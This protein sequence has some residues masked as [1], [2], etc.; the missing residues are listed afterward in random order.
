[1]AYTK[2]TFIELAFEELGI[3]DYIFDLQPEE[4][5]KAVVRLDGMMARWAV[6]GVEVG[7]PLAGSPEDSDIDSDVDL[8]LFAIEP[9]YTNLAILLGP[10][11][12]KIASPATKKTARESLATLYEQCIEIPETKQ[13]SRTPLGAGNKRWNWRWRQFFKPQPDMPPEV[14]NIT[15]DDI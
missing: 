1:M 14:D 7:Y 8:P 12:G 6:D 9:I 15:T 3:G 13:S 4:L 2:R 10:S 11:V 5:S